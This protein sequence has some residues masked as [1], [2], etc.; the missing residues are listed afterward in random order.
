[1]YVQISESDGGD[2]C[3]KLVRLKSLTNELVSL[4]SSG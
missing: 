4:G 1:M 3:P 2:S